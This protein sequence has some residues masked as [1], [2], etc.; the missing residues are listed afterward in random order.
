MIALNHHRNGATRD[1][2]VHVS[3]AVGLL[4]LAR[5]EQVSALDTARI[6]AKPADAHI[7]VAN[8]LPAAR[9]SDLS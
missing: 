1:R 3:E 7:D 6:V 8:D 4:S 5:H 2:F 9:G